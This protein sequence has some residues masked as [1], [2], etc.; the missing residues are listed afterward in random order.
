MT[1]AYVRSVKMGEMKMDTLEAVDKVVFESDVA[2]VEEL[3]NQLGA[4]VDI[5]SAQLRQLRE[6]LQKKGVVDRSF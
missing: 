4:D 2:V 3:A 6:E 1:I 5:L